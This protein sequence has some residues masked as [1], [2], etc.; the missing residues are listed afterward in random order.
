VVY[1]GPEHACRSHNDEDHRVLL[2]DLLREMVLSFVQALMSAEADVACGA[3]LGERSVDRVNQRSEYRERHL[4]T[5]STAWSWPSQAPL[6]QLL[7]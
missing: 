1:E 2:T 3:A 5:G 4:D 6:R 7:P